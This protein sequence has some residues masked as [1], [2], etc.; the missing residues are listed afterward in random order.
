M[1][2]KTP[3]RSIRVVAM[4]LLSRREHSVY[5]LTRKLRQ[6]DFDVDE[7]EAALELLRQENLQSD[8]RFIESVVNSRVNAGFG[9]IKIKH[10]LQQKGVSSELVNDYLSGLGVEWEQIMALQRS[11]KFGLEI[12][13]DYK[14]KMKQARFLQNRGFSPE[15]VM[16]LF[17]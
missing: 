10:E 7:V 3:P 9:P 5:E 2:N 12:P 6:R 13:L 17:R 11:K 1:K 14:E 8:D 15:S 16:R 4:N